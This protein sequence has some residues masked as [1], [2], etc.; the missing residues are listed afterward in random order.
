MDKW[1]NRRAHIPKSEGS[2]PSPATTL[3]MREDKQP[4]TYEELPLDPEKDPPDDLEELEVLIEKLQNKSAS[5]KQQLEVVAIREKQCLSVDYTRVKRALFARSQ[6]NKSITALQRIAKVRRQQAA[7]SS[8]NTFE[9][10]F[11]EAAKEKLS[12]EALTTVMGHTF[13]K[14][15]EAE[16][17]SGE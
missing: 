16:K 15:R 5:I 4:H 10:F 17:L 12:A 1:L 13:F 11:F 7:L 8:G 9:K 3:S 14:M 2:I 6:T